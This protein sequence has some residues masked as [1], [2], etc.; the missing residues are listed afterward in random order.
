MSFRELIESANLNS[1][2][3]PVIAKDFIDD[4]KEDHPVQTEDLLEQIGCG[5]EWTEI[6][7]IALRSGLTFEERAKILLRAVESSIA[8]TVS[9][10]VS[11]HM[12]TEHDAQDP[13]TVNG[14]IV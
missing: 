10:Y 14:V 5:Y 12:N 3:C 4:L 9:D 11:D 13:K 2:I 1:E 6:T 7:E 8:E